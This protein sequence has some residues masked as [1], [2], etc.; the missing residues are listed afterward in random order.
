[1]ICRLT[2]ASDVLELAGR[3]GIVVGVGQDGEAVLDELAAGNHQLGSVREKGALV[4]DHLDLHEVAHPEL[5]GQPAG[6]D[7]VVGGVATGRVRQQG[8]ALVDPVEQRLF[9][10]GRQ[11]EAPHRHGDDFGARGLVGGL[12]GGEVLVL[13]GADE[14]ARSKGV[15][16]ENQG[17][18]SLSLHLCH[19]PPTKVTTSS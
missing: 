6:P 10:L 17:L 16:P 11:V 12:H 2:G 5:A 15:L 8:D 4:A 13:A 18:G 9:G 7:G 1:M 14:Q 3:D 19:P